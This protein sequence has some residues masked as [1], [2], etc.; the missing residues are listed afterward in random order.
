MFS[1]DLELDRVLGLCLLEWRYENH[2]VLLSDPGHPESASSV[3]L[4]MLLELENWETSW[5]LC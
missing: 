5:L 4:V 2:R 1:L 3:L